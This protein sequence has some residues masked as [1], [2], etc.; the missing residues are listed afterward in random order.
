MKLLWKSDVFGWKMTGL[1]GKGAVW[2]FGF[3]KK[4]RKN[5]EQGAE[6][7]N[8]EA[9]GQDKKPKAHKARSNKLAASDNRHHCSDNGPS[10]H[11]L[12]NRNGRSGKS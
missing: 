7:G 2:F 10:R 6:K 1:L 4:E 3:S 11:G 8:G 5:N 9:P 12:R